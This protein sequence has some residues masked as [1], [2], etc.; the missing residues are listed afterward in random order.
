MTDNG[1]PAEQDL[2]GRITRNPGVMVGKPVVRGTRL[3]VEY[4][5]GLLAHGATP[6]EILAE[7]DGLTMDDIRACLLFAQKAQEGSPP[8]AA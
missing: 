5:L 1:Q 6:Q 4:I 7:Y 3:T 2:L 8:P